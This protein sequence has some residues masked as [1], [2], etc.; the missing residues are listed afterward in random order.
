MSPS[1]A[2]EPGCVFCSI[3]E[4]RSP[5][6]RVYEDDATVAF[7]DLFPFTRGHLL[8][9]PRGHAPRITDYTG[10]EQAA[11][12]RS[13]AVMCGRVERLTSDYNVAMNA[14]AKAGQIVFHVHFHVIPRYGESNPFHP[15]QRQRIQDDDARKV[16]AELS[17]P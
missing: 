5:A 1:H 14:G 3:V 13:L 7:L 11:L 6:F 8:V 2:A 4:G 12:I 17:R 15:S 10:E 16:V 9:V